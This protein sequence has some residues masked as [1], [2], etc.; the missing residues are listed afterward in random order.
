MNDDRYFAYVD[1]LG[2]TELIK[3]NPKKIDE[4]YNIIDNLNVFDDK[5]FKAVV[6]SDTILIHNTKPAEYDALNP[7]ILMYMLEF[8]TDLLMSTIELEIHFRAIIT[9]GEFKFKALKNFDSY[10]GEAL[11]MAHSSE[12]QI[13]AMGIFLDNKLTPQNVSFKSTKYN[14]RF[15]F[16]YPFRTLFPFDLF[17]QTDFPVKEYIYFE[18]PNELKE[19]VQYFKRLHLGANDLE[20]N[21]SV[22]EK[23][24]NTYG[25]FKLKYSGILSF[26]EQN[27]FNHKSIALKPEWIDDDGPRFYSS[28]FKSR[29]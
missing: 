20:L 29:K 8:I 12:K 18:G 9:K 14:E 10:Y 24:L 11:V 26:L 23:Y 7:A 4:L 28:K 22:R 13:K 17:Q 2:F 16:V 1:I 3:K 15:D 5:S 27:N 6:F 21:W 19:T 25:M